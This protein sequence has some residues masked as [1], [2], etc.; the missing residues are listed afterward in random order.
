MNV[1]NFLLDGQYWSLMW[2]R[3]LA[4]VNTITK[5]PW[6]LKIDS[7]LGRWQWWYCKINK[8]YRK[9]T[10]TK[11]LRRRIEPSIDLIGQIGN[12]AHHVGTNRQR[13]ST[14]CEITSFNQI[15]AVRLVGGRYWCINIQEKRHSECNSYLIHVTEWAPIRF[16]LS[17][18]H[19]SKRGDIPHH[20]H[21]HVNVP[22]SFACR[23]LF[24]K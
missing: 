2:Y 9:K 15:L 1:N 22:I 13:N 20:Q 23:H 7:S 4:C 24:P 17:H 18:L 6:R 21:H 14:F 5:E 8:L 10:I 12:G 3:S 19:F 16:T 11:T